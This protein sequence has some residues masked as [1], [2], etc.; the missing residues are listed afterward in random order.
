MPRP[1]GLVKRANALIIYTP[2][3]LQE[4]WHKQATGTLSCP[5][6]PPPPFL[7]TS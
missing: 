4:R 2:C 3:S 6:L 5:P 7:S 1:S